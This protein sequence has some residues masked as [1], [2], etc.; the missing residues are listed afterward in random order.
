[1]DTQTHIH[2]HTHT[3]ALPPLAGGFKAIIEEN[4]GRRQ[5]DTRRLNTQIMHDPKGL[6]AP[7][8][9]THHCFRVRDEDLLR[10]PRAVAQPTPAIMSSEVG[11]MG[12]LRLAGFLKTKVSLAKEPYT[13]D[14]H[15]A[16]ETYHFDEPTN[17]R[18]PIELT[19]DTTALAAPRYH[20]YRGVAMV[21]R[22]LKMIGLFRKI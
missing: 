13:R 18:H 7:I 3:H 9:T 1:M 6:A 10:E 5:V 11:G 20:R 15:S 22:L 4:R 14:L 12:L 2:T 8:Y 21:S 16:K 19:A 17:Y